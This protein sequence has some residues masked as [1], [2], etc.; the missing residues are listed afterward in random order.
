M[1]TT[2]DIAKLKLLNFLGNMFTKGP[3]H[4]ALFLI[5]PLHRPVWACTDCA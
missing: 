1:S 3:T 2:I 5:N 4:L